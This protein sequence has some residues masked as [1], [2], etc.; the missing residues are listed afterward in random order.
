MI[1]NVYKK[2]NSGIDGV[3]F[4]QKIRKVSFCNDYPIDLKYMLQTGLRFDEFISDKK[5]V[6]FLFDENSLLYIGKANQI[7]KRIKSHWFERYIPFVYYLYIELDDK[8]QDEIREIEKNLIQLHC[9]YF[10]TQ[11]T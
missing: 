3:F 4:K 7:Y 2:M 11:H 10:N 1:G 6:Y 8:N 5:G 9:P